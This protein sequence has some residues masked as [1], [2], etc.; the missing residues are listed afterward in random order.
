MTPLALAAIFAPVLALVVAIIAILIKK[1]PRLPSCTTYPDLHPCTLGV[2]LLVS[3]GAF[4]LL[5]ALFPLPELLDHMRFAETLCNTTSAGI[6]DRVCCE[7]RDA[8][9]TSQHCGAFDCAD[10]LRQFEDDRY[11]PELRNQSYAFPNSCC[12]EHCCVHE[13]CDTCTRTTCSR[14][15]LQGAGGGHGGGGG[16]SGG[17]GGGSSHVRTCSTETYDCNCVCLEW[18]EQRLDFDCA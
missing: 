4:L 18:G 5:G 9:C 16:H 13:H 3:T 11:L 14:R 6:A 2:L 1:P 10:A 8:V 17:S 7:A 12:G 15:R